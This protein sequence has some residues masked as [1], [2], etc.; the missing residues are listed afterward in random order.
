MMNILKGNVIK[1]FFQQG[2]N[3]TIRA[4]SSSLFFMGMV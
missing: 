3:L 4:K 2:R 1:S